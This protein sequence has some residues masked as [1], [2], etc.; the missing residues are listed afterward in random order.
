VNPFALLLLVTVSGA[1]LCLSRRF[2]AVALVLGCCYMTTG[3]GIEL[4]S[5]S[6]P[7]FRMVLLIGA[8]RVVMR[9]EWRGLKLNAI[10][11]LMVAFGSYII[12]ASFFRENLP[13][14]GPVGAIGI[15]YNQAL[16]Y[17]LIRLWIRDLDELKQWIAALAILLVPVAAAMAI[18][19]VTG[20]SLFAK[21]GAVPSEL[22]I[23][24]GKIR[25]QGPF[26]HPILAGTVGAV[27][28]PLFVMIFRE[29][30]P[31]ALIGI[32]CSLVMVVASASS[33][34]IMSLLIAI[35]ALFLWSFRSL[36]R[37][38][39]WLGVAFYVAADLMMTRPGYYLI[40]KI[41]I[42]GGSTGWHRSRLIHSWLNHFEEWWIVGTDYTRHWMPYG[43]TIGDG[44]HIDITNHYIAMAVYGGLPALLLCL[45][46]LL[47]A[48]RW[49]GH[50]LR[51]IGSGRRHEQFQIWCLGAMLFAHCATC[52]AVSYFDQSLIFFWLCVGAISSLHSHYLLRSEAPEEEPSAAAPDPGAAAATDAAANA[53]WRRQL[54]ER[55]PERSL[56]EI[57]GRGRPR[58]G[59]DTGA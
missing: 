10:D 3:Q 53:D 11:K 51:I 23:R 58:L 45:A 43:V 18:E 19:K 20:T 2:A 59:D 38:L 33:G 42:T 13:G 17:L 1:I 50:M 29:R 12:L 52:I 16:F 48:F 6:L 21:F 35:G 57:F 49:V 7:V 54:R 4:G 56:D 41:D 36:V 46:M 32:G 27:C 37:Y 5:I 15:V 22:L 28:L 30:R 31:Q 9:Q 40:S 47:V 44:R 14:A 8:A 26:R 55:A 34:P 25:A 39:V 24:D